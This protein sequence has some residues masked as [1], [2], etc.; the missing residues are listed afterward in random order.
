MLPFI[1]VSHLPSSSSF[2]SAV[3]QPLGLQYIA[4]GNSG[5]AGQ[6]GSPTLTYGFAASSPPNPV[7]E[8]RQVTPLS[9]PLKLSRLVLS[10]SSPDAVGHF[11]ALV[12]KSKEPDGR[13][14]L[15]DN[16]A[17]GSLG[18]PSD[19]AVDTDLDGNIMEVV[20]IPPPGY[21]EGYAGSTVRKTQSNQ[22]EV[23]R[24]LSWNYDVVAAEPSSNVALAHLPPMS[25]SLVS[26]RR[27]GRFPDDDM[28]PVVRRSVTSTTTTLVEP[29]DSLV[30]PRQNSNGSVSTSTVVGTLLGVAAAGAAIGAGVAYGVMKN[31]RQRN[32]FEAAPFQRRSTFPEPYH[33]E[34]SR[35]SNHGLAE[36]DYLPSTGRRP[37]PTLVSRHSY[38]QALQDDKASRLSSRFKPSGAPSIRTNSEIPAGRS[39]LLLADAEHRSQ[40]SSRQ[41]AQTQELEEMVAVDSRSHTSSRH[42]SSRSKYAPSLSRSHT[43]DAAEGASYVSARSHKTASTVRPA[44]PPRQ[45]TESAVSRTIS[46]AAAGRVSGVTPRPES[47]ISAREAA[48]APSGSRAA[49]RISARD[50]PALPASQ[51]GSTRVSARHMALPRSGVGSSHAIWDKED[52]LDSIA[53]SDSISCVGSRRSAR[54]YY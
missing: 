1:E 11:R 23:S 42:T 20:Y 2:Y 36:K 21:P 22:S 40:A 28:S 53:P 34:G 47:Y 35:Y 48:P 3:T 26:Y 27:P 4:A 25:T 14:T 49:S 10:A 13:A 18:Y 5:S 33:G 19:K 31:D 43:F 30:S 37:P 32:E 38:S 39:Q 8:L 46:Q 9:R 12:Q 24:I 45:Q 41:S 44:P 50:L 16:Q 17:F 52:D 15:I 54:L 6:P 29:L 51:A 7:F